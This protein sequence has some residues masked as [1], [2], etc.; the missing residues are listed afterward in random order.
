M[1][2]ELIEMRIGELARRTGISPRSLRY[3]EEQGLLAPSRSA[4]GYR[5]YDDLAVTRAV[6]IRNLLDVGLTTEDIRDSVSAGCLDRLL[7]QLPYCDGGLQVAADRLA[8]LDR[9]IEVL[10]EL[11]DRLA[12]SLARSRS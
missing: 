11:R 10:R 9:R 2:G 1:R 7:D 12:D 5:E 6:N 4:N 3:Y 8:A